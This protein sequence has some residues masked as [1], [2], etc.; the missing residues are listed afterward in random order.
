MVELINE[1]V[2]PGDVIWELD[3]DAKEKET[4]K[5][6]PGLRRESGKI[7]AL[8]AGILKKKEPNIFWVD[9][10]Q[11]R[12]M[13]FIHLFMFFNLLKNLTIIYIYFSSRHL[14]ICIICIAYYFSVCSNKG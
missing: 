9:N 13:N 8:K 6:G 2:L 1:V 4:F 10:N 14:L 11:R 3:N 7:I 12:V 5:L